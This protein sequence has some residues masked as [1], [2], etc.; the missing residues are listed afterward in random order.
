MSKAAQDQE[1]FEFLTDVDKTAEETVDLIK[2]LRR[3][4]ELTDLEEDHI[5]KMIDEIRNLSVKIR[6]RE[7]KGGSEDPR[8]LIQILKELMDEIVEALFKYTL[9]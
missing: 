4:S 7:Q 8:S 2:S 5:E 1:V 9:R 3:K 6:E